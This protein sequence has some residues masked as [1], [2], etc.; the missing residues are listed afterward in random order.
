MQVAVMHDELY[1]YYTIVTDE[2]D[3]YLATMVEVDAEIFTRWR[4]VLDQ[5][6]TVQKE[7]RDLYGEDR[8]I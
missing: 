8:H 1:P 2:R 5:F 6:G 4:S 3:M 7:M